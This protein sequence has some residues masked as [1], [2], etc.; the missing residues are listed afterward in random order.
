M[1]H[2]TYILID[3]LTVVVCFAFSFHPKI[4]FDKHFLAFL[5]A[6]VLVAVPFIIW[7]ALFTKFGIWWFN[8]DYTLGL[9]I[10]GLPIEE[11]LF[12]ICIPF[13]CVFTFF[14]L[15][16]FFKLDWANA[17]NNTIVFVGV[18][19]CVLSAL[20]FYDKMYTFVTAVA[21]T[22]VLVYLHFIANVEWIGKASLVYLI[23][24]LG[25]FPVNG[26]LT[27]SGLP[28]AVVNYNPNEFLVIRMFTIPIEDAV[29]G[30]TQFLLVLYFFKMFQK[31]KVSFKS[32]YAIK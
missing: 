1:M 3:F 8:T 13:A 11:V 15:D 24:M 2:Y 30:Y 20:L 17:F 31:E 6:S 16:K 22:L 28:S 21:A 12:F 9:T 29:Y 23:L 18:I 19:V 5:K 25:F 32:K 10:F 26:I 14:C 4:R 27:G 7:D